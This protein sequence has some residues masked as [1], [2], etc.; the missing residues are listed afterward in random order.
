MSE[1]PGR[2]AKVGFITVVKSVLASFFGVQSQR[3]RE[4]DFAGGNPLHFILVGL[5]ATLGFVLI[6]WGLV[7]LI[8]SFST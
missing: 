7:S 5:A 1:E 4:R 2:P 6:M 3:N 8:L